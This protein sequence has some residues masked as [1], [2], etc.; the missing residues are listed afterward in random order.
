MLLLDQETEAIIH[1]II[2]EIAAVVSILFASS[3]E[4][5]NE[6]PQHPTAFLP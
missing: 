3:L 1:S 5:E 6:M 2:I 4:I